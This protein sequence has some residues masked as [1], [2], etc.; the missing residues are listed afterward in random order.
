M[1]TIQYKADKLEEFLKSKVI[2]TM[3]E[4]K[5]ALGT[6]V[7]KTVLRKLKDLSYRTS[8]SHGSSYYSLDMLINFDK[9]GLWSYCSVWFSRYGTLLAT[10]KH[11][12]SISEAGCLAHELRECLHVGVKESLLKLTRRGEISRVKICGLYLYCSSDS[13]ERRQQVLTRQV[14]QVSE[15]EAEGSSDEVKAAL[16]IFLSVLDEKERRLFAGLE[17]LKIGHGGDRQ[18]AGLLGLHAH[19]VARGRRQLLEQDVEL[20]RVRKKS[21]SRRPPKKNSGRHLGD[22]DLD[23]I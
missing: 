1:K 9:K 10:L 21:A 23:E 16:I 20:E 2:A 14:R 7:S 15:S 17:S 4:M 5:E 13:S 8:Y 22:Q 19:T 11:F 18:I 12:T 6:S 3:P